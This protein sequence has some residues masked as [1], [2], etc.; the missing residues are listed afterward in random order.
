MNNCKAGEGFF[1]KDN[2]EILFFI[3]LFLLIFYDNY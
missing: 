2:S 3:I 1:R